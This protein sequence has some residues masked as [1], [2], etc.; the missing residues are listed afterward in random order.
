VQDGGIVCVLASGFLQEA[1]RPA[2]IATLIGNLSDSGGDLGIGWRELARLL[3]VS[4]S[5]LFVL[6]RSSIDPMLPKS[7]DTQEM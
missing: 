3:R 7:N 6:E 5:F 1:V 4:K 2:K